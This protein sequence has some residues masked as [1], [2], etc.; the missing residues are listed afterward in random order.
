MGRRVGIV[1][2]LVAGLVLAGCSED[3]GVDQHG[4]PVTAEQLEGQWLVIN[5]WAEWCSPCRSEIAQLNVL[6]EQQ[7]GRGV[8]V[9]GVNF[10]GLQG[11]ELARASEAL[12]IRFGVLAVDPAE[13]LQL[14]PGE[15]LPVTYIVDTRGRLRE[16]LLGEQ[17][18]AG[19][20]ARLQAL[21][22]EGS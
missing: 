10:D 21:R 16:R 9:V 5:Y 2:A 13:R 19:L 22:G 8:R 15:V 14:P 18:A 11:A 6:A 3:W 17:T 7:Q 1:L 20:A 4:R 12:G